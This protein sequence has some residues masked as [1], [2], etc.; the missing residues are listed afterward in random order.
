M[1]SGTEGAHAVTKKNPVITFTETDKTLQPCDIEDRYDFVIYRAN[2]DKDAFTVEKILI[3]QFGINFSCC[4]VK[5]WLDSGSLPK[6]QM[7]HY[8]CVT[9]ITSLLPQV[10]TGK[11]KYNREAFV[12]EG[13]G[14]GNILLTTFHDPPGS[15][16]VE[17]VEYVYKRVLLQQFAT[18]A[19]TDDRFKVTTPSGDTLLKWAKDHL[20]TT[21]TRA[22]ANHPYVRTQTY[23]QT[24]IT[25]HSPHAIPMMQTTDE[26]NRGLFPNQVRYDSTFGRCCL[27]FCKIA[28]FFSFQTLS[29]LMTCM[30]SSTN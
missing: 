29:L 16:V 27:L 1:V 22:A 21:L 11:C 17:I 23:H 2:N 25:D 18:L 13:G 24:S 8:A 30:H 26:S 3:D 6:G 20:S 9:C 10:V 7:F 5:R 15:T 14:T 4:N 28:H 12:Q 19:V